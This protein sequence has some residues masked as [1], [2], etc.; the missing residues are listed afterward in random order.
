M[1]EQ[2]IS[3]V[4][5]TERELELDLSLRTENAGSEIDLLEDY[6]AAKNGLFALA[7]DA[8]H[9][10]A[11]PAQ[12]YTEVL[13]HL[14][15]TTAQGY[16]S[17]VTSEEDD[18]LRATAAANM[19]HQV[20]VELQEFNETFVFLEPCFISEKEA[21]EA[22]FREVLA[23]K[24]ADKHF[25]LLEQSM[26]AIISRELERMLFF[27]EPSQEEVRQVRREKLVY[28]AK[29]ATKTAAKVAVGAA[30]FAAFSR[31]VEK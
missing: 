27:A 7:N 22:T 13:E 16:A 30:A 31:V 5:L 10:K 25:Q 26:G 19:L 12:E 28:E 29:K 2:Q 15:E 23:E 18:K 8:M 17:I 3:R 11:G 6:S 14:I 9:G 20:Q 4:E 24:A 21:L 1:Y